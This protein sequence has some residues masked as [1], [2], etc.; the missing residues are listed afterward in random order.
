MNYVC[1]KPWRLCHEFCSRVATSGS[2]LFK[3]VS[4]LL[5]GGNNPCLGLGRALVREWWAILLC[6]TCFDWCLFL[7]FVSLFIIIIIIIIITGVIFILFQ[8]VNCFLTQPMGFTFFSPS[9]PP[10]AAREG[11]GWA[12]GCM[13]LSSQLALNH[14]TAFPGRFILSVRSAPHDN[15]VKTSLIFQVE[16][17]S[18]FWPVCKPLWPQTWHLSYFRWIFLGRWLD[19]NSC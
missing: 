6:I 9:S 1:L 7:L 14:H 8:L 10:H 2:S 3:A 17:F 4:S 18:C 13:A 19:W 5:L 12:S 16:S 11:C 15:K